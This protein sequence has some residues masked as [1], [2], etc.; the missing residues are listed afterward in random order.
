MVPSGHA[1]S[2]EGTRRAQA[3]RPTRVQADQAATSAIFRRQEKSNWR[4][5][6]QVAYSRIHQGSV[7]PRLVSKSSSGY[8][9]ER[10]LAH[11][12]RLHLPEQGLPQGSF[13]IAPY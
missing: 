8:E 5:S 2:T 9:E 3:S 6:S 7:L 4:Q 10:N 12:Y 1:W 11:V 13:C